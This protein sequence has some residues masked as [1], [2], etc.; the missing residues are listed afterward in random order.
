RHRLAGGGT[1]VF[2]VRASDRFDNPIVGEA[3]TRAAGGDE[4]ARLWVLSDK[5]E[6]RIGDRAALRIHSGLRV[7]ELALVTFE[8][9][10]VI[11]Y[12]VVR[13]QAGDT[14]FG[15]EV[16]DVHAPNVRLG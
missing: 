16:L 2:R 13:L 4:D 9:D 14:P 1:Y 5:D 3:R 11:G 8:G 6:L 12:R 10:G 7:G 15:F